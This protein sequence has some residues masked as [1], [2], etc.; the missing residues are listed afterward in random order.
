MVGLWHLGRVSE[1][2]RIFRRI[3]YG[4]G[5]G[6]ADHIVYDLLPGSQRSASENPSRGG[7][8]RKYEQLGEGV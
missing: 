4:P 1:S 5:R 6:A 2:K 7:R 8:Q 3:G